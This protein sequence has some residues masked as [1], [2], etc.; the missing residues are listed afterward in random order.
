MLVRIWRKG[1]LHT[2]LVE[3]KLVQPLWKTV[4]SFLNRLKI[5]LS[6][7]PEILLLDIYLKKKKE[8]TNLKRYLHPSIHS[9]I[10]YN[11]QDVEATPVFLFFQQVNGL[12]K[13]CVCVC[14]CVCVYTVEYYSVI[15]KEWNFV[16]CNNMDGLQG[17][18][19]KWNKSEKNKYCMMSLTCGI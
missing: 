2:L 14:V 6:Y 19:A 3:C 10:I 13:G 18:Y 17:Y 16:I 4:W 1:N 11:S 9:S 15:K 12:K 7:D 8:N 5:E